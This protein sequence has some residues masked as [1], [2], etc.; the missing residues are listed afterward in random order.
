VDIFIYGVINSVIL[1]L[2]ALGFSLVYG[3]SRVSNFAHGALYTLTAFLAYSFFKEAGIIYPVS[4]FLSLAIVTLVGACMYQFLIAR[5]RGMPGS[6]MIATFAVGLALMEGLRAKGYVGQ[7]FYLPKFFEGSIEIAGVPVDWQRI[8]II[9]IALIVVIFLVLF[10]HYTKIGLSLRAMAQD[11]RAA[12][13]IG[14]D[15]D[16]GAVIALGLGS[17]LAG[18]ASVAITPLGNISVESGYQVLINAIAV[19]IIGGL[20]SWTGTVIA[21]FLL[22]F[23]QMLTVAFLGPEWQMVVVVLAILLLLI[24]KPSGILGKQKELEERV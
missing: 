4:V 2:M 8:S 7:T 10:T 6:E 13:M 11:E 22:G 9:G 15:S 14:M 21:A 19:C 20:G 24:I 5:V 3:V 1:A 18:V 16:W 17:A 23:A 12:M